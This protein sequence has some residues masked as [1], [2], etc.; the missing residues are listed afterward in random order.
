ML[1]CA[2]KRLYR[3]GANRVASAASVIT[4]SEGAIDSYSRL[5]HGSVPSCITALSDDQDVNFYANIEPPCIVQ[6]RFFSSTAAE[7]D[8]DSDGNG[9]EAAR[10]YT[11]ARR[12]GV[13]N[14]AIIAHVDHGKTTL[15]DKLLWTTRSNE[16]EASELNRL[17]DRWVG[18]QVKLL[19][20]LFFTLTNFPPCI[21]QWRARAR[22]WNYNHKQSHSSFLQCE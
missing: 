12:T 18:L 13:R 15:V 19:F 7:T 5:G 6:Q 3:H 8:S 9:S 20:A 10:S 17:M 21:S 16:M 1:R 4:T 2:T 14:V 22:A 11:T